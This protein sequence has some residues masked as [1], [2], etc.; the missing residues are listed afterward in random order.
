MSQVGDVALDRFCTPSRLVHLALEAF[1]VRRVI[2]ESVANL[3]FEVIDNDKVGEK[4]QDVFDFEQVGT[5]EELH[6]SAG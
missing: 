4:W 1:N 6:G 3:V 5:F 2:L